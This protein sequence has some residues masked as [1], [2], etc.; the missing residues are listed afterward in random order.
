M[1]MGQMP[2]PGTV[3]PM[4]MGGNQPPPVR[5]PGAG[6]YGGPRP[7]MPGMGGGLP[8]SPAPGGGIVPPH[9]RGGLGRLMNR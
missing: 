4:T 7:G 3:P 8:P 2:Q 1:M 5:P 9:M 6:M